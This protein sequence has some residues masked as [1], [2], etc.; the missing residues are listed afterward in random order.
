MRLPDGWREVP[1]Y[2]GDKQVGLFFVK[3]NEIHC[4]RLASVTGRW[5]T[6]Q[7]LEQLTA[8]IFEQYGHLLTS[9]GKTNTT[10]QRFV[11]RLGFDATHA[12]DT[13]IYYKAERLKHARH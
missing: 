1:V 5:L 7:V 3:A 6:R 13:N 9:V 12:D 4:C 2:H 8:P 11:T 10:G